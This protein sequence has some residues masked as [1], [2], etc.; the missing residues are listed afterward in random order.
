MMPMK[1][2]K[3]L[4]TRTGFVSNSSSSSFVISRQA[5]SPFQVDQIENHIREVSTRFRNSGIDFG[6]ITYPD[7]DTCPEGYSGWDITVDEFYVNGYT[8]MDNFDMRTFLE[9]IGVP[10]KAIKW[11]H[12]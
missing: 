2:R 11:R 6:W 7:E 8:I 9:E 1:R 12:G 10:D 3:P 4:K 5:V